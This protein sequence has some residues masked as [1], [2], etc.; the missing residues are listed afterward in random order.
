MPTERITAAYTY[1]PDNSSAL[2]ARV[3]LSSSP[4]DLKNRQSEIV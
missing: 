3:I 4:L 2:L 1:T